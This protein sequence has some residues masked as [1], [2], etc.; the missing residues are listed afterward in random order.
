MLSKIKCGALLCCSLLLSA[1][2]ALARTQT[3]QATG[4]Y[5]MGENDSIAA[6]KENARKD[7]MRN[8]AEQAGVY[9]RSYSKTKNL[10]LTDDQVEI[11]SIQTMQVKDCRYTQDY[12]NNTLVIQASIEATI[13][14]ADFQKRIDA[15]DKI[16]SLQAQLAQEKE[17]NREEQNRRMQKSGNDPYAALLIRE[18]LQKFQK[19]PQYAAVI[20][21]EF[22]EFADQRNGIVPADIY[23]RMALLDLYNGS[24]QFQRDLD[25]A[26]E[27][28]P[29]DPLYY[30]IEALQTLSTRDYYG[31]EALADQALH[32]NGR[33]WPAY[34]VR[35]I[36]K[37]FRGSTRKAIADCNTA[38]RRGGQDHPYVMK[39][40]A[41]LERVFAGRH[42]FVEFDSDDFEEVFQDTVK[43][44]Y[45]DLEGIK[46][47]QKR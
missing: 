30:T 31:A 5:Q 21:K 37:G 34:Y 42:D 27:I 3:I 29:N 17:K 32:L 23:G 8:A 28:A 26:L 46:L 43:G 18:E 4:V 6:A 1:P 11:I 9:V 40:H 39:Y 24:A 35:S 47:H 2:V 10:R 22:A 20:H 36:A 25:K 38:I 15:N 19:N 12:R 13:D 14:D 45:R 44:F 33:Y 16:Q 7:A 41:K